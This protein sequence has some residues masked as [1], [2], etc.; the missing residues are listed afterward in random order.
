MVLGCMAIHTC[1]SQPPSSEEAVI[2]GLNVGGHRFADPSHRELL[3][4]LLRETDEVHGWPTR[5]LQR[6]LEDRWMSGR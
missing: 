6:Q 5:A 3:V 2:D 4:S 1:N